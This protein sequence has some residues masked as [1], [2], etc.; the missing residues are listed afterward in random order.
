[1]WRNIISETAY[2]RG[3]K[4]ER[5]LDLQKQHLDLEQQHSKNKEPQILLQMRA[6]KQEIDKIYYDEVEKKNED[7]MRHAL[8]LLDY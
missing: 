5:L 3:V 7:I 6:I 1:M 8:K 4:A 2:V